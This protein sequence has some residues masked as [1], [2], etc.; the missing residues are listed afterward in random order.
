MVEFGK[1]RRKKGAVNWPKLLLLVNSIQSPAQR[2]NGDENRCKEL[3]NFMYGEDVFGGSSTNKVDHLGQWFQKDC[4]FWLSCL[5]SSLTLSTSL[6]KNNCENRQCLHNNM[7]CQTGFG[8]LGFRCVCPLCFHGEDCEEVSLGKQVLE[9]PEPN[10]TNRLEYFNEK[11]RQIY[12][13]TVCLWFQASKQS[14]ESSTVFSLATNQSDNAFTVFLDKTNRKIALYLQTGKPVRKVKLKDYEEH[15]AIILQRERGKLRLPG[16]LFRSL[17]LVVDLGV[18]R[19]GPL[20]SEILYENIKKD[21][22]SPFHEILILATPETLDPPICSPKW[23]KKLLCVVTWVDAHSPSNSE[24][25]TNAWKTYLN[26]TLKD[27][28]EKALSME[29]SL[30]C[31]LHD[32]SIVLGADQDGYQ[33]KF[34]EPFLGNMTAV[35]IWDRELTDTEIA[36]LAKECPSGIGN[37][38]SWEGFLMKFSDKT[39]MICPVECTPYDSGEMEDE[40]IDAFSKEVISDK[41]MAKDYFQHLK[42][43]SFKRKRGYSY[44]MV[45]ILCIPVNGGSTPDRGKSEESRCVTLPDFHTSRIEEKVRGDMLRDTLPDFHISSIPLI[46]EKV[47]GDMDRGKSEESRCVTLPDFHTSRIEEKVGGDMLRD[48]LPDFHISSI[49]LIEEKV[50]GDMATLS[51]LNKLKVTCSNTKALQ[52][53]DILGEDHDHVCVETQKKIAHGVKATK[54]AMENHTTAG[55]CTQKPD[56]KLITCKGCQEI[57]S[58]KTQS[59]PQGFVVAFDNIDMTIG[60]RQMTISSQ[61]EDIHWVNHEMVMNRVSGNGLQSECPKATFTDIPNIEFLPDFGD[62]NRQRFHYIVLVSRVLAEYFGCF[63]NLKD[64]CIKHLPHKYNKELAEQSIKVCV[65]L[66]IA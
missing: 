30:Q 22:G 27:H 63:A 66:L 57:V 26:G 40:S 56:A 53:L 39:R 3:S 1:H 8:E 38:L 36:D 43:L 13:I 29:D 48:T 49:P 61:N 54:E 4:F 12:N 17:E 37:F 11:P 44:F 60:R 24:D 14:T 28:G 6:H 25:S 33:S 21:I 52:V 62:Q 18:D 32:G 9:F 50:R 41:N 20:I 23:R 15:D 42:T 35:N 64:V 45:L 51:R 7:T 58:A 19:C 5:L 31:P 34:K 16:Q 2:K 47:R 65:L 10:S 55:H 46:E 59:H